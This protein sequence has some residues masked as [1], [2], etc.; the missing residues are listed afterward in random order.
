MKKIFFRHQQND[1]TYIFQ[2]VLTLLKFNFQNDY[3]NKY[4]VLNVRKMQK[5]L[6]FNFLFIT[7]F[8]KMSRIEV[9]HI[10]VT[11]L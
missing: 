5:G 8:I 4:K 3:G 1:Q 9:N 7:F 10:L 11:I 6:N 2:H